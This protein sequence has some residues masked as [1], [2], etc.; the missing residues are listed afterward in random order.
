MGAARLA[1]APATRLLARRLVARLAA[2][3]L[4]GLGRARRSGGTFD[5][6]L[7]RPDLGG[8]AGLAGPL[9]AGSLLA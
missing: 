1:L 6:G 5:L 4:G 3:L 8:F 9:L 7:P 2:G